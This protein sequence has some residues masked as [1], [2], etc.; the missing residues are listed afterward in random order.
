MPPKDL[1]LGGEEEGG[2]RKPLKELVKQVVRRVSGKGA[3]KVGK[4]SGF[5]HFRLTGSLGSSFSG[6]MLEVPGFS[7]VTRLKL[8]AMCRVRGGSRRSVMSWACVDLIIR[9]KYLSDLVGSSDGISVLGGVSDSVGEIRIVDFDNWDS[10]IRARNFEMP[11]WAMDCTIVIVRG[12]NNTRRGR[13]L[14]GLLHLLGS[15][16]VKGVTIWS[17]DFVCWSGYKLVCFI[18]NGLFGNAGSVKCGVYLRLGFNLGFTRSEIGFGRNTR[19]GGEVSSYDDFVICNLSVFGE[20][21]NVFRDVR[22]WLHIVCRSAFYVKNFNNLC[23]LISC[24]LD[25]LYKCLGFMW[26]DSLRVR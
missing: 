23:T 26:S 2:G 6:P 16:S 17:K 4:W 11:V 25:S 9:G 1:E 24:F 13:V 22:S 15:G 8:S 10:F 19:F 5:L 7:C 21:V 12:M 20:W 3:K 18:G 14:V